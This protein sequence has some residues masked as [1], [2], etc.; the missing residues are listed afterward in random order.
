MKV[1]N[2]K[3]N[4]CMYCSVCLEQLVFATITFPSQSS[5][6]SP[7]GCYWKDLSGQTSGLPVQQC[8]AIKVGRG[9]SP[10]HLLAWISACCM[11]CLLSGAYA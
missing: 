7:S 5:I 11:L 3:M 10:N 9:R 4:V 1:L 8:G 2:S 6:I